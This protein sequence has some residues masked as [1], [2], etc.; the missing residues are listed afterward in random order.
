M[1]TVQHI[2]QLLTRTVHHRVD[3]AQV[4]DK[5]HT[6]LLVADVLVANQEFEVYAHLA[7]GLLGIVDISID[8]A[9]KGGMTQEFANTANQFRS[10]AIPP[11]GHIR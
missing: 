9:G 8:R 2:V 11:G 10:C 6:A 7:E 5:L 3:D 4:G 1:I